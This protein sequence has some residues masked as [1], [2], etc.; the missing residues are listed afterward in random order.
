MAVSLLMGKP[1]A[2]FGE[3]RSGAK[4][5]ELISMTED[6]AGEALLRVRARS[7]VQGR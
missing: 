6:Y 5:L 4:G 2:W 7:G 3:K 1:T